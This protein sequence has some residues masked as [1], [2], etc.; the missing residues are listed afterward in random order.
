MYFVK[1]NT[2]SVKNTVTEIDNVFGLDQN[3]NNKYS[4]SSASKG[5]HLHFL[6][7]AK[8]HNCDSSDFDEF[9]TITDDI[10]GLLGTCEMEPTTASPTTNVPTTGAPITP[11]PTTPSPTTS[12]PT[13][14]KPF[15][16]TF[17]PT[18][19]EPTVFSN[20]NARNDNTHRNYSRTRKAERKF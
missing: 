8:I 13:T 19:A 14:A 17:N 20:R 9:S 7:L 10:M 3:L 18:T 2:L 1:K 16:L 15:R 4:K 12:D 6:K 5:E 11:A